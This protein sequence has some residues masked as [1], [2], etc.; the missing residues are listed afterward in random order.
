MQDTKE[1]LSS[2]SSTSISVARPQKVERGS[3]PEQGCIRSVREGKV[4]LVEREILP[5]QHTASEKVP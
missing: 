4:I 1:A 3:K 5:S 2:S